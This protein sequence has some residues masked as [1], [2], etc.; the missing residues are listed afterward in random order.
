MSHPAPRAAPPWLQVAD[1]DEIRAGEPVSLTVQLEREL[2]GELRPVDA[3]RCA[4]LLW[5]W[6]LLG[7]VAGG[8]ATASVGAG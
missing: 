4:P 6:A 2:E 7:W 3:P 1:K 5:G 8:S